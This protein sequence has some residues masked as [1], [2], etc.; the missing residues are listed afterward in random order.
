MTLKN[1]P[2]PMPTKKTIIRKAPNGTQYVYYTLRAYRNKNGKPTSQTISI[3][4]KDT[5]TNMLIPN[6]NYNDLFPNQN[7]T[8]TTN[9]TP[10][11]MIQS[12]GTTTTLTHIANQLQLTTI[13]QNTFP[14]K[15]NQLLTSTFYILCKGNTMSYIQD[16]LDQTKTNLT[17]PF[18]DIDASK[19]FASITPQEKTTFFT[20]WIKNRKDKEYHAYDVTSLS[21]HSNNLELAEWGYNRDHDH[22][23]QINLGIYYGVTSHIPVY[24]ALYNGSIPD[25]SYLEFMMNSAQK[26]GLNTI[27]LILDRIFV[28]E[29]NFNYLYQNGYDFVTALAADRVEARRLVDEKKLEVRK[30]ANRIGG[31]EVYGVKCPVE[32]YGHRLWAHI[33][34]DAEKAA[35]DEKALYAR[36][37]RL[38][39]ELLSMNKPRKVAKRFK[40]YFT[41]KMSAEGEKVDGVVSYVLDG[42]LV[43]K[44]LGRTGF[45][46]L[47]SS[48][49]ELSCEEVLGLYR[50]R[51]V[52]EKGFYAFKCGLDFRR[53]RVHWNGTLEGK[54]FVGFLALVLRSYMQRVLRVNVATKGLSFDK[55]LLELEKVRVVTLADLTEVITPLTKLQR[56]ILETLNVP[57]DAFSI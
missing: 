25:K 39:A 51:D 20:S 54:V 15:H 57:L 37:E 13:L 12:T 26:L 50:E 29:D 47:L 3:G 22:L 52:V 7:Q 5:N 31:F 40:D 2:I 24:Y 55:V 8:T 11:K 41:V 17:Q 34:F 19:L 27:S 6:R 45:F 18:T 36:V 43:D 44:C 56:T 14:D 48:S 16:W 30:L 21:T 38:E 1:Q 28:T 4:K 46:V 49:A 23:P 53:V 33:Y 42:E 32:L 9:P 35:F 10:I